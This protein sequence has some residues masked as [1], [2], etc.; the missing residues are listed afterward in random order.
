MRNVS[1]LTTK[2]GAGLWN[3]C[4]PKRYC[5]FNGNSFHHPANDRT[6]ERFCFMYGVERLGV[7]FDGY[8]WA[9][10]DLTSRIEV[11]EQSAT[12]YLTSIGIERFS[13]K[14]PGNDK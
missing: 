1:E 2:E 10:C 7:H 13:P 5:P 14:N 9:D 12:D 11:D 8:I 4:M 3:A 6:P